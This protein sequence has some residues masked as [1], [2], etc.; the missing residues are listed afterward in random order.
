M[1]KKIYELE[2]S[3]ENTLLFKETNPFNP[4]IITNDTYSSEKP[5]KTIS[6]IIEDFENGKYCIV[7]SLVQDNGSFNDRFRPNCAMPL[8]TIGDLNKIWECLTGKSLTLIDNAVKINKPS[9]KRNVTITIPLDVCETLK[10]LID[11]RIGSSDSDD[12]NKQ[13]SLVLKK[14]D[15]AANKNF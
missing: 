5:Y 4:F 10:G 11:G 13:M 1:K 3:K 14:L 6:I 2:L 15:C 9:V 12:F 7:N 8:K